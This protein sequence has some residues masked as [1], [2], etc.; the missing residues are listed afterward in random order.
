MHTQGNQLA[1]IM[2]DQRK[3]KMREFKPLTTRIDERG[4]KHWTF[5]PKEMQAFIDGRPDDEEFVVLD[6]QGGAFT[7]RSVGQMRFLLQ[8]SS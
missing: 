5:D 4:L 7:L 3:I 8:P 2:P 1:A 6:E